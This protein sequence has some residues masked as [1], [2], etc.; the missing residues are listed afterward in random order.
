MKAL[1]EG[2]AMKRAW[3][4][5]LGFA[6]AAIGM[7]V[8]AEK[9]RKAN[10]SGTWIL[11]KSK[12]DRGTSASGAGGGMGRSGGRRGGG[13][14]PGGGGSG[15]GGRNP[16]GGAPGGGRRGGGANPAAFEPMNDSS[17]VIEHSDSILKV[18]HKVEGAGERT[19]D[20][21]QLFQLDGSE[22]VNRVAP[23]NGELKSRTSWEKDKLVTLGTLQPSGSDSA[24]RFTLVFKQEIALS[25]D[26]KTLTLKTRMTTPRGQITTTATFLRQ[27]EA[28][29]G[30][31][32]L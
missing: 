14:I 9:G 18:V 27:A 17:V 28:G 20:Y 10:F 5:V 2:E 23:G 8:A 13:G 31:E 1:L 16:G 24:A 4:L 25:K 21:E 7:I 6:L 29:V 11:D 12:T 3:I 32:S 22:S 30:K 15:G 19:R 26:G